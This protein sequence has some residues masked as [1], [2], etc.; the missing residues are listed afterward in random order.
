MQT[1][2]HLTAHTTGGLGRQGD[3]LWRLSAAIMGY[4]NGMPERQFVQDIAKAERKLG[5]LTNRWSQPLAALLSRPDFMR[6]F[7]MFATLAAA[8]GASA[9]SR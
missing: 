5:T 1:W 4:L 2:E 6:D 8:S 3:V 9:L 7:Y